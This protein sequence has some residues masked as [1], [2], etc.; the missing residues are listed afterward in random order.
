VDKTRTLS[1]LKERYLIVSLAQALIRAGYEVHREK[2]LENGLIPDLYVID[3]GQKRGFAIEIKFVPINV[4][5]EKT[6]I[7]MR[8]L[9][10][11]K[12]RQKMYVAIG[13]SDGETLHLDSG[14]YTKVAAFVDGLILKKIPV[15]TKM[16]L[17]A[18]SIR[19]RV[20]PYV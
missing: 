20:T 5:I 19:R 6:A 11:S 9:F 17:R 3:V 7:G 2:Y 15:Q 1:T 12:S 16:L 14:L 8:K 13:S 4:D 10:K 18:R